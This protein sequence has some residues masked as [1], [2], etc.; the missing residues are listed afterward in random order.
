MNQEFW[1][2]DL[3]KL[4]RIL[5]G[6]LKRLWWESLWPIVMGFSLFGFLAV[7]L[8]VVMA[9]LW[10]LDSIQ[11]RPEEGHYKIGLDRA[12]S[13]C[14]TSASL[15]PPDSVKRSASSAKAVAPPASK[16]DIV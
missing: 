13:A 16:A 8:L 1:N 12:C 4:A 7:P 15:T 2:E 6:W 5:Y 14:T 10:Y 11:W 9:V 3:L